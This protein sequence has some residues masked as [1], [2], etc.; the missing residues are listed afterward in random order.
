MRN[1]AVKLG[2]MYLM[3]GRQYTNNPDHPEIIRCTLEDAL[4]IASAPE[5]ITVHPSANPDD[6]ILQGRLEDGRTNQATYEHRS[7]IEDWADMHT[8][9]GQNV[10]IRVL[11]ETGFYTHQGFS[12]LPLVWV[13]KPFK[14]KPLRKRGRPYKER[15]RYE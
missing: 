15:D 6:V 1:F 8:A 2:P 13:K 3:Y 7:F 5:Q 14:P 11:G 10:V 4:I 9:E 12:N